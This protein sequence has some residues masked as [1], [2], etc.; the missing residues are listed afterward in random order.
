MP[1]ALVTTDAVS[2]PVATRQRS[3]HETIHSGV[4]LTR[5]KLRR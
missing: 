3:A 4:R 5:M 2:L 1:S